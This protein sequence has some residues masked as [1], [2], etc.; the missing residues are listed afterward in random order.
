MVQNVWEKTA[1]NLKFVENVNYIR[2]SKEAAVCECS[3]T[4]LHSNTR[5]GVLL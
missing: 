3:A 5:D 2:G 4:D 1:G